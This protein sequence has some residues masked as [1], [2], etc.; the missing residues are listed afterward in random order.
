MSKRY[1]VTG[2]SGLLGQY[3]IPHIH[4]AGHDVVAV[5]NKHPLPATPEGISSVRCDIAQRRLLEDLLNQQAPDVIIHAAGMTSVDQCEVDPHGAKLLN[6]DVPSWIA[7]WADAHRCQYVFISSDHVTGGRK[8]FFDETDMVAPVN[9]YART[10]AEAEIAVLQ[11]NPTTQV[12]RTNFFGRGPDWRKSLTDWL[13]DKALAGEPVPAFTDSYFSPLSAP[14]LSK[15]ITDLSQIPVHGIYHAGGNIRVSKYDFAMS[16]F[17]FFG[18]DRAL[19]MPARV[20]D[21]ALKAPRPVDMSMSVR[22]I[23]AA[24]GYEM[25]DLLQS[26]TAI[27][28]DYKN[29]GK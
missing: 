13:W 5:S 19:V 12:I 6:T 16:F 10:K 7:Q 22:K 1:L 20:I 2:A 11:H 28:N 26:F 21:Q 25:P 15:V 14:H 9:V 8:A 29:L 27:E 17:E 4:L 24:L 23:E 3:L 18:L